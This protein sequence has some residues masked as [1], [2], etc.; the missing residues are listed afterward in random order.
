LT[1][2]TQSSFNQEEAKNVQCYCCGK[3]GHYGK[4]CPEK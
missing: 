2:T 3:E 4:K 1:L